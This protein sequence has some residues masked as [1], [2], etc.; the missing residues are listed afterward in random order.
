MTT[1]DP[2]LT[3]TPGNSLC[4]FKNQIVCFFA[5]K[6]CEFFVCFDISPLSDI[7]FA[8]IFSHSVGFFFILLIVSFVVKKLFNFIYFFCFLLLFPLPEEI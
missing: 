3:E 4:A 6:L 1:L 8:N 7:L 2:Q 5:I